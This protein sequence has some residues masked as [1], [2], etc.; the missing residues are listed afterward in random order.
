MHCCHIPQCI[1]LPR[2]CLTSVLGV[3]P[4][5]AQCGAYTLQRLSSISD[6]ELTKLLPTSPSGEVGIVLASGPCGRRS[7]TAPATGPARAARN[8]LPLLVSVLFN[9]QLLQLSAHGSLAAARVGQKDR[10]GPEMTGHPARLRIAAI[11]AGLVGRLGCVQAA[12]HLLRFLP[13]GHLKACRPLGRSR[14]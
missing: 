7:V 5:L 11:Q 1:A 14:T 2:G 8:L 10:V 6:C 9:V 4:A 3:Q 12:G 13:P